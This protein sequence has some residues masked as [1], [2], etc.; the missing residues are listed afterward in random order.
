M[1]VQFYVQRTVGNGD[2]DGEGE[3]GFDYGALGAEVVLGF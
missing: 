3:V 2:V 1:N